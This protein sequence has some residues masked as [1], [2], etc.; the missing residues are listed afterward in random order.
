MIYIYTCICIYVYVRIISPKSEMHG[1]SHSEG[2]DQPARPPAG[3]AGAT[4]LGRWP[5]AEG[6]PATG[7]LPTW[8]LGASYD[9][10]HE[11]GDAGLAVYIRL[12]SDGCAR[13]QRL[14][15]AAAESTASREHEAQPGRSS[16]QLMCCQCPP[17]LDPHMPHRPVSSTHVL[18]MSSVARSAYAASPSTATLELVSGLGPAPMCPSR[19]PSR[20]LAPPAVSADRAVRLASPAAARAFS[21]RAWSAASRLFAAMRCRSERRSPS[22]C[23]VCA[24]R[25]VKERR[26]S[27]FGGALAPVPPTSTS[28]TCVAARFRMMVCVLGS[29][30]PAAASMMPRASSKCLAASSCLPVTRST[31]PRFDR[32]M[33]T[34]GCAAPRAS[35]SIARARE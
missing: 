32:S 24:C 14:R 5:V 9:L 31:M 21:T 19:S 8:A 35:R 3:A 22:C 17:W 27:S 1:Q 25:F 30:R 13:N 4:W 23:V 7:G 12:P 2:G 16:R 18:P 26:R 28:I 10:R 15:D 6:P 20:A 11:C 29:S 34:S 33:A